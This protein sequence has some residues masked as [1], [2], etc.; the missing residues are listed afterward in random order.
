MPPSTGARAHGQMILKPA[1]G[2]Q[3]LRL[4][5]SFVEPLT[6][7]NRRPSP[8]SSDFRSCPRCP[9]DGLQTAPHDAL[10]WVSVLLVDVFGV[11]LGEQG[12]RH[13]DGALRAGQQHIM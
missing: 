12:G 9:A 11:Y 2:E 1:S 5:C 3:E 8:T 6:E 10:T 13:A 7:A 4:T